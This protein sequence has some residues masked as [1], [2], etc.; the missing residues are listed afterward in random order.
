MTD[1]T[2]DLKHQCLCKRRGKWVWEPTHWSLEV[3]DVRLMIA[4]LRTA[5]GAQFSYLISHFDDGYEMRYPKREKRT[6]RN[7]IVYY[8]FINKHSKYILLLSCRPSIY[9]LLN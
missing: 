1:G 2:I 7:S 8:T 4:G 6:A 9:V 5:V 3:L